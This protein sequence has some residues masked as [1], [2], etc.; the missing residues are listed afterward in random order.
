VRHHNEY[1]ICIILKNS[2][3]HSATDLAEIAAKA[4]L[5][6]SSIAPEH[7]D[8]VIFGCLRMENKLT[9]GL[10]NML[11]RQCHPIFQGC[12]LFG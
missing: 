12:G 10:N 3:N 6:A 11:F 7:I 9:N 1:L 8:H 4:A 5:K 2:R